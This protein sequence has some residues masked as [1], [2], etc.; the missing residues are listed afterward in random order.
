[1]SIPQEQLDN[2]PKVEELYNKNH[3]DKIKVKRIL[4]W[5]GKL[6]EPD[7]PVSLKWNCEFEDGRKGTI[8]FKQDQKTNEIK[9]VQV[10][11]D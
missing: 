5:R 3:E 7:W 2:I 10:K 8:C 11:Y 9:D 6:V 1:M 4:E